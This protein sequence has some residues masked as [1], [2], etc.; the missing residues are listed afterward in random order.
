VAN[1]LGRA[2]GFSVDNAYVDSREGEGGE[3]G[4]SPRAFFLAATIET[5]ANGVVNDDRYEYEPVADAFM[6]H[7]AETV[8]RF[9]G[10]GKARGDVTVTEAGGT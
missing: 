5:N 7:V 3:K 9:V 10:W 6:E 1:K 8:A 4:A 2:Y